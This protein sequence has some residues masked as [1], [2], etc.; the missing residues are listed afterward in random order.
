MHK[1]SAP[2]PLFDTLENTS[3]DSLAQSPLS[4]GRL[5]A[6]LYPRLEEFAQQAAAQLPLSHTQ[7]VFR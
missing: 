1:L 7:L 6:T 5:L 2:K 3:A 4:F